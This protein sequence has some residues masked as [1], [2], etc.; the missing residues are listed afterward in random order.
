M[1]AD[2]AADCG[3]IAT[4]APPP[5]AVAQDH[6]RSRALAVIFGQK[7]ATA[8]RMH[9]QSG[10]HATRDFYALDALWLAST[11]QGEALR[12][13]H[14]LALEYFVL[15]GP[16]EKVRIRDIHVPEARSFLLYAHQAIRLGIWQRVEEHRDH[17][18]E[19]GAIGADA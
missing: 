11:H 6:G 2:G 5:Q 7:A 8:C 10:K 9:A 3:R 14:R 18:A 19:N 16:V 17:H 12:P 1:Q 4:E 13:D 15:R